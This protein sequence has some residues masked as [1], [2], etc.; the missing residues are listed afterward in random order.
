[1]EQFGICIEKCLREEAKRRFDVEE[2]SW[3]A[4]LYVEEEMNKIK[5]KL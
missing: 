1:M 5:H 3:Y 2:S 4:D